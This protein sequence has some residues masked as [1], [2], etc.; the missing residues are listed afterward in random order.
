MSE[1]NQTAS[2]VSYGVFNAPNYL[3]EQNY[4]PELEGIEKVEIDEDTTCID[5]IGA[6]CLP[7]KYSVYFPGTDKKLFEF[8]E[9]SDCC[10]RWFFFKC[11]IF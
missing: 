11:K 4:F 8:Q 6:C 10:E 3:M 7:N 1:Q 9:K 2:T 5:C